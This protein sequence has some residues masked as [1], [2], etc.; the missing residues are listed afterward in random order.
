MRSFDYGR[1]THLRVACQIIRCERNAG[2]NLI[3][4]ITLEPTTFGCETVPAGTPFP[5]VFAGGAPEALHELDVRMRLWEE[6][7]A[8]LDLV[9]GQDAQGVHY[10][11]ATG[12]DQL[13]V[14]VDEPPDPTS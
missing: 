11:F 3:D 1:P 5:L 10:E 9:V 13:V 4:L 14:T 8:I 12:H 6:A 2:G 7:C